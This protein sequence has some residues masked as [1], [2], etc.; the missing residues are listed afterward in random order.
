MDSWNKSSVNKPA[1]PTKPFHEKQV[2]FDRE[3][4]NNS[5]SRTMIA[6]E[7]K[8]ASSAS[9]NSHTE[10]L[11]TKGIPDKNARINLFILEGQAGF[12]KLSVREKTALVARNSDN[13]LREW[14]Y[15]KGSA[16]ELPRTWSEFKNMFVE[17]CTNKGIDNLKKYAEEKWID[18]IIRIKNTAE[19][20]S[21]PE[22]EVIKK[23]RTEHSPREFQTLFFSIDADL[24]SI[25]ERIREWEP[26]MR[27]R[28]NNSDRPRTRLQPIAN[29]TYN[30]KDNI[31]CHKCNKTGHIQKYCR[32]TT[33]RKANMATV[34]GQPEDVDLEDIS[35]NGSNYTSCFDSGS[36]VNII[37]KRILRRIK[38]YEVIHLRAPVS[39]KL[40]NK[41]EMIFKLKTRLKFKYKG[42]EFSAE[43]LIARDPLVDIIMGNHLIKKLKKDV[44]VFPIEC[45]ILSQ[46]NRIISWTRP[47]QNMEK[48]EAFQKL[49]DKLSEEGRI[50]PSNSLWC[51]PVV[52]VK[53]KN[54][55]FR[56]TLDLTRLNDI[57]P[58]DEF[59]I[60]KVDE[61][62]KSLGGTTHFSVLDLK[63]GFWQV[64]LR[65]QDKE[66]IAFLD[67]NNKLHQFTRMPQG[68]KNSPALFQRG[69]YMILEG[70]VGKSCFVYIDDILVFGRNEEEHDRN[71]NEIKSRLSRCGLIVNEKKSIVNAKRVDFLGYNISEN[72]VSPT[73]NRSEAISNYKTPSNKRELRRFLG[74]ANYD[75]SFIPKLSELAKPL[76]DLIE[77]K[78]FKW[79]EKEEKAFTKIKDNWKN[80]LELSLPNREEAFVLE[81]D[82]S[83]IGLGGV[84][85]QKGQPVAYIS[86]L[87][88]KAEKNYTITEKEALAALW[89]MEKF[90]FLLTGKEFNLVTDHKALQEIKKKHNFGTPRITRWL[91]R[92]N[93]FNF[94]V[95]YREGNNMQV[96][97]ALSRSQEHNKLSLNLEDRD[98]RVLDIHMEYHHRK[99]IVDILS[100]K[101]IDMKKGE[102][103]RILKNC[104]ECLEHEGKRVI[105]GE[106]VLTSY[107]G[108]VMACDLMEIKQGKRIINAID[109][110]SR[111]LF[112]K[113]IEAKDPHKVIEFLSKIH[114]EIQIKTL[115]TDNGK[116][117][118]NKLLKE[119]CN[120]KNIHH[121]L[122]IPYYHPSNGRVERV[123]RTVRNALRKT[124]GPTKRILK[125]I[126][127]KYNQMKHRGIGIPPNEAMKPEN[128]EKAKQLVENYAKE[129]RKRSDK[130]SLCP[131]DEILI[132]NELKRNKMDPQFKDAGTVTR[133]ISNNVYE[134]KDPKGKALI[135][136]ISQLK[137][138]M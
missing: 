74:M 64:K 60:P 61:I 137:K 70:L 132:K 122:A 67:T 99:D 85:R 45:P 7:R 109:Y 21:L 5:L 76:Y 124:K 68:F 82:A 71:L 106:H 91:S 107:P 55:D 103:R 135:R 112:S 39:V 28:G 83:E 101:G 38:D 20:N 118:N 110:F 34:T 58:L 62:I 84:L 51:H 36:S 116:E 30:K 32:V 134:V 6:D 66:K 52:I 26:M 63:D 133:R 43:F 113:V 24:S 96:P 108:E 80:K 125:S 120:E 41:E 23:L 14:Y 44:V 54:G 100:K 1:V 35:I 98:K 111:K 65:N 27:K 50:E 49:V 72:C 18:Y 25:I 114:K 129:F 17:Y 16:D 9:G 57:V 13:A 3:T 131:G 11:F 128:Q 12:E 90:E 97:D 94:K 40:I 10:F 117:F 78:I 29:K 69:M 37:A 126:V 33:V 119:W 105:T 56:F 8:D 86:R 15:T 59:Q 95:L 123:N 42:K 53:K 75:R 89:A 127:D 87:L 92:F 2:S 73:L 22:I 121:K 81:T 79:T 104:R 48:R 31:R 115:L 136:H 93:N 19:I 4:D 46:E 47:I 130:E 88:K 138:I 77:A 102:L